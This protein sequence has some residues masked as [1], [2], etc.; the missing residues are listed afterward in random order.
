MEPK[1][2]YTKPTHEKMF[3][4][5][6]EPNP[7]PNLEIVK[8]LKIVLYIFIGLFA[9]LLMFSSIYTISAGHRGVILTMGKPSM[10]SM[11]E[12]FHMKIP[13]IQTVKKMEVRT[14]KVS[15]TADSA[16]KDLQDVQTSKP[17][18]YP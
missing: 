10:D 14:Q 6:I 9:L 7:E 18:G 15:T 17:R 3:G 4:S 12:G 1:R 16:S 2:K 11:Q 5:Y 13:F 8:I